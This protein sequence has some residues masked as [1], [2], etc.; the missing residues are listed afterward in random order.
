MK[1]NLRYICGSQGF[2]QGLI[3]KQYEAVWSNNKNRKN[4]INRK[5]NLV[6]YDPLYYT[7]GNGGTGMIFAGPFSYEM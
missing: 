2:W 3:G 7:G 1:I 4:N 6:L 5:K